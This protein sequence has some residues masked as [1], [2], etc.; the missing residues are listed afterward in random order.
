MDSEYP[1]EENE[2]QY[3]RRIHV[4]YWDLSTM[5]TAPAA[6]DSPV[7]QLSFERLNHTRTNV[8]CDFC[9]SQKKKVKEASSQRRTVD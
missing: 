1:G 6:D 7:A 9:R 5:P 3:F 4:V 2:T 8:A